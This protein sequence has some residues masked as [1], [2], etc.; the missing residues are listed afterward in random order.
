MEDERKAFLGQAFPLA[1]RVNHGPG[2]SDAQLPPIEELGGQ[3]EQGLMGTVVVD[4]LRHLKEKKAA[5]L[6]NVTSSTHL[7]NLGRV[8]V[9]QSD[10]CGIVSPVVSGVKWVGHQPFQHG[11]T[12]PKGSGDLGLDHWAQL[13]G[14]T[15]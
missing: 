11:H 10:Q 13:A 3:H 1:Q 6:N 15:S 14:V 2:S 9:D 8:I 4:Q 7:C 12:Q 5:R